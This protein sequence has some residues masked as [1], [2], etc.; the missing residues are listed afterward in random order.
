MTSEQQK[1]MFSPD[2]QETEPQDD[3]GKKREKVT[4]YLSSDH[5]R[6]LDSLVYEYNCKTRGK[7]VNRNDIVRYLID[8]CTIESLKDLRIGK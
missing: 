1:G 6:K 5:I 4:I 8:H 3:D 7:R 2:P